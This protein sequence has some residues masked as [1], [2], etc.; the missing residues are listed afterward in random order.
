M[1]NTKVRELS[2]YSIWNQNK[3]DDMMSFTVSYN[4]MVFTNG[5]LLE[6]YSEMAW[7]E[8]RLELPVYF[9]RQQLL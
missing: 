2:Y 4:L 3:S 5:A 9:S 8:Q 6:M 1:T 7:V